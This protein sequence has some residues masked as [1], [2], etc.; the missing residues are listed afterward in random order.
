M[1]VSDFDFKL[2]P[3]QI[4]QRPLPER[5]GSRL[6]LLDR[7]SGAWDD[8]AFREFPELLRGDELIVVNNT[9]VLP[10]RLFGRR[11][12]I[13]AGPLLPDRRRWSRVRCSSWPP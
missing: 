4:A 1:N 10:A 13:H 9:R 11:G 12:G 7:T 6:L 2:P 3:A 8:R 5:D